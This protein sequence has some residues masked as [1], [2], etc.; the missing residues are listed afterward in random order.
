[1]Y[2]SLLKEENQT[3]IYLKIHDVPLSKHIPSRL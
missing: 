3:E 2:L 1:M